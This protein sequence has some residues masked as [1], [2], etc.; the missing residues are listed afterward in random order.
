MPQG[1]AAF[2]LRSACTHHTPH[3]PRNPDTD[4]RGKNKLLSPKF[5]KHKL[6]ELSDFRGL[7]IRTTRQ[8]SINPPKTPTTI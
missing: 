6:A 1:V 7:Y 4:P 2:P 8:K 3:G 5:Q